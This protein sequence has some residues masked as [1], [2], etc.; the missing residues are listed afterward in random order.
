MN[1]GEKVSSDFWTMVG[2]IGQ[3]VGAIV[4]LA[5]VIVALNADKPKVKFKLVE[6]APDYPNT[7]EMNA[8]RIGIYFYNK[9]NFTI[10][11]SRAYFIEAKTR[12]K[13]DYKDSILSSNIEIG[14]WSIVVSPYILSQGLKKEGLNGKVTLYFVLIDS[15]GREYKQSFDFDT[16]ENRVVKKW[17]KKFSKKA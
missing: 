2:A 11:I 13:I 15:A 10:R 12:Q 9:R 1:G 14:S 16:T 5:A 4:T 8:P 3:W 17:C 7:P 6:L